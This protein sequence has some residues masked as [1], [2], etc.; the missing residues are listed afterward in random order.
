MTPEPLPPFIDHVQLL[1]DLQKFGWRDQKLESACGFSGGY[2]AKLR[3]DPQ[4]RIGYISAARLW[5]L[6]RDEIDRCGV[7]HET[8]FARPHSFSLVSLSA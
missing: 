3:G 6:W 4:Q 1:R 2:V 8:T 5:N 7:S